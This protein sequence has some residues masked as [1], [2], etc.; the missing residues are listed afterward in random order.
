MNL[1]VHKM[2]PLHY[3]TQALSRLQQIQCFMRGPNRSK[4]TTTSFINMSHLDLYIFLMSPIV[5]ASR[6]LHLPHISHSIGTKDMPQYCHNFLTYKLMRPRTI[7]QCEVSVETE[8]PTPMDYPLTQD[9]IITS[10]K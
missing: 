6:S 4:L 7:H 9:Y 8:K 2:F 1:G 3:A 5:L 10:L